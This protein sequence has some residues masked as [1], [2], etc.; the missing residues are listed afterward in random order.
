MT[1][2]IIP[3]LENASASSGWFDWPGGEGE[4]SVNGTFG[5]GDEVKLQYEGPSGAEIDVGDDCTLTGDGGGI[6]K[7]GPGRIKVYVNGATGVY[8]T[9]KGLG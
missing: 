9:V 6:F 3:I 1:T 5:T 4:F 7:L 8:A 2:K